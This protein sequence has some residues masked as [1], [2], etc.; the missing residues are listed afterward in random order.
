MRSAI[1]F[2]IA[3]VVVST[4]TKKFM[5][6]KQKRIHFYK[7]SKD[8]IVEKAYRVKKFWDEESF[9]IGPQSL[10]LAEKTWTKKT[11]RN[12]LIK[13]IPILGMAAGMY[14]SGER[15]YN[16]D[17]WYMVGGEAA[18]GFAAIIPGPGAYVSYGLDTIMYMRDIRVQ[19]KKKQAEVLI[20]T[21]I[22]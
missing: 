11:G 2:V 12:W 1:I 17:S 22:I 5:P 21:P 7:T 18:S 8:L 10:D 4:Q 9:N 16:R 6:D 14:Y 3:L 13:Q 19:V 20:D 15:I